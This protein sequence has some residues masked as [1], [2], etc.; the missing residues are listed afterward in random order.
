MCKLIK[1]CG[2]I[3]L[4]RDHGKVKKLINAMKR[5]MISNTDD[6]VLYFVHGLSLLIH[7]FMY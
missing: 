4:D 7:Y 3:M 5:G 6:M 2:Q 1:E